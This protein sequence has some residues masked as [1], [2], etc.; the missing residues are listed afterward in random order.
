[1][2]Q[3]VA[4][5]P[6]LGLGDHVVVAFDLMCYYGLEYVETI[7]YQYVR[8]DYETMKEEMKVV[9]WDEELYGK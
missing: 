6:P 8:G 1:M 3:N 5:E 7:R 2:V 4:S 9:N